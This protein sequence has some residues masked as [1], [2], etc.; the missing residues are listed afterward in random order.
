MGSWFFG[1]R[2]EPATPFEIVKWWEWRRPVYNVMVGVTGVVSMVAS[3]WLCTVGWPA[4][5]GVEQFPDAGGFVFMIFLYGM[6]ANVCYTGGWICELL[7]RKIWDVKSE[8]FS[9]IALAMGLGFS[10][11][12]TLLPVVFCGFCAAVSL[13]FRSR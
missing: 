8:R 3:M 5:R 11:V 1:G 9:H 13:L 10:V 7:V 4:P 6:G 12:L 2:R